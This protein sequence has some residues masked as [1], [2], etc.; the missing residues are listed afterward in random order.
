MA[1]QSL[2]VKTKFNSSKG[3]YSARKVNLNGLYADVFGSKCH[4]ETQKLQ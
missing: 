2:Y 3:I 1:I 4:R